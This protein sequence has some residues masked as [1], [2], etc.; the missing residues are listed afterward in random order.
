MITTTTL[1]LVLSG[2]LIT[3]GV[4]VIVHDVRG[5]QR[6]RSSLAASRPERP[7]GVSAVDAVRPPDA[8]YDHDIGVYPSMGSPQ[9]AFD[10]RRPASPVVPVA[11]TIAPAAAPGAT[12]PVR[13]AE[14]LALFQSMDVPLAS[15]LRAVNGAFAQVDACLGPAGQ[16]TWDADEA[17]HFVELP[18]AFGNILIG[19]L[20]LSR[21]LDEL[22]ISSI[23]TDRSAGELSRTRRLAP[24]QLNVQAMAEAMA[25][26]AWPAIAR[27]KDRQRR[28]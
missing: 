24:H 10:N 22:E 4:A 20:R 14:S 1:L 11:P 18:I 19:L 2:A 23:A 8:P 7:D 15:A 3:A 16:P 26:C 9:G 13:E 6:A 27:H 28:P 12:G 21:Y 25:A 5:K 17:C